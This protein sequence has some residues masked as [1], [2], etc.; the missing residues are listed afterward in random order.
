MAE[1]EASDGFEV[2]LD[3]LAWSWRLRED[4]EQSFMYKLFVADKLSEILRRYGE[5]E[6]ARKVAWSRMERE[7]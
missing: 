4:V 2:R 1:V 5:A 7:H 6:G 3:F